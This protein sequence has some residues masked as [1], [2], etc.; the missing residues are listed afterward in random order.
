MYIVIE[1][2]LKFASK[3]PINDIPVLGQIMAWCGPG[4]KPLS[5]AMMA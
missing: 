1:I 4:D 2:S 3:G 5:E